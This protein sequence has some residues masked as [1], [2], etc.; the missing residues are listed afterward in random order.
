MTTLNISLPD[1]MKD[2]VERQAQQGSYSSSSEYVRALVRDGAK[3]LA[4]TVLE[5]KLL[6]GIASGPAT[7]MTQ[8]DWKELRRGLIPRHQHRSQK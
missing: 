3:R 1:T 8:Q 4:K 6:E 5:A 2:F 7:E